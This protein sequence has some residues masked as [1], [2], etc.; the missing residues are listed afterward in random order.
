MNIIIIFNKK[1]IFLILADL[2]KITCIG[3]IYI[4]KI[5][6]MIHYVLPIDYKNIKYLL[7]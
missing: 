3:K 2:T 5:Y 6:L 4:I 1:S 7:M